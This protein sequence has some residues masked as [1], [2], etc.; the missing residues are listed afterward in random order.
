MDKGFKI[1]NSIPIIRALHTLSIV[2]LVFGIYE[3]TITTLWPFIIN[4]NAFGGDLDSVLNTFHMFLSI[5]LNALYEPMI[6][7]S[8]AELIKLVRG[9]QN[10]QN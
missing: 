3:A 2:L 9:Q 7:I 1:L 5:S 8:I 4:D 10:D 6:L